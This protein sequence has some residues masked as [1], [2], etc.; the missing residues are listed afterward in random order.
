MIEN[1][2]ISIILG[3]WAFLLFRK[4][5]SVY[6]TTYKSPEHYQD[7]NIKFIYPS[8]PRCGG[9]YECTGMNSKGVEWTCFNPNCMSWT[10]LSHKK[11]KEGYA[12]KQ[13]SKMWREH[14]K[15]KHY[16]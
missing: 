8:C 15:R 6:G 12:M 5:S 16:N 11:R 4:K 10:Q 1:L 14:N 3:V 13:T 9:V 2:L 7:P